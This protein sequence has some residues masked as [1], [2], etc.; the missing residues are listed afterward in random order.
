[1]K[2]PVFLIFKFLIFFK[3]KYRK[4]PKISP[5]MYKPLQILYLYLCLYL[6]IALKYKVKQSKAV[7]SFHL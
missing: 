4:I 6:E 3:L 2:F 7:N 1:M 5:C